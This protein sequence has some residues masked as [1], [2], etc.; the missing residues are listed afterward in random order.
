[1]NSSQLLIWLLGTLVGSMLFFAAIVAPTV[2]RALATDT[3]GVFLRRLFPLYF[4]WGLVLS[5]LCTAAAI[6]SVNLIAGSICAAVA[7]LFLYARFVLLAQI[8]R[9]R[10]LKLAGDVIGSKR[11]RSL[12]RRSVLINALQLVLLIGLSFLPV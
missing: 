12:H 4:L 10:D 3:A 8:N 1:M 9:A 11:F 2:F 7:L 6:Y 5:I